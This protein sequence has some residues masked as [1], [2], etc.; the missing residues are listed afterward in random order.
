MATP[1]YAGGPAQDRAPRHH[2]TAAPPPSRTSALRITR[3][4]AACP[5]VRAAAALADPAIIAAIEAW[6]PPAC[7]PAA[8]RDR[9][10]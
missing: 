1:R 8:R 9:A 4:R 3:G 7:C 2:L 10:A 5:L 6:H